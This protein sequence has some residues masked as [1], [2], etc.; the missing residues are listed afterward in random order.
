MNSR[1]VTEAAKALAR[2][3]G[4]LWSEL[5]ADQRAAYRAEARA[6]AEAPVSPQLAETLKQFSPEVLENVRK[7]RG[8]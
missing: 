4:H 8:Y 1:Q 5:N 2:M 3:D 7:A 6:E